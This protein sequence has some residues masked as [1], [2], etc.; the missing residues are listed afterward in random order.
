MLNKKEKA[1]ELLVLLTIKL[2]D[3]EEVNQLANELAQLDGV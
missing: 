3:N 2:P 1:K